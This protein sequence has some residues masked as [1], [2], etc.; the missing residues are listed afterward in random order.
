MVNK[1]KFAVQKKSVKLLQMEKKEENV[2][3]DL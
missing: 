1:E 2:E 3:M